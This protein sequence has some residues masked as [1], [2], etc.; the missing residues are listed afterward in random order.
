VRIDEVPITPE[1]IMKA[2]AEK[3]AGRKPRF[4]PDHFPRVNW[5]EALRVP[6]PWEGGDGNAV[7]DVHREK[8]RAPKEKVLAP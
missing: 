6:P 3:K 4:G 2:L 7:N 1:K 8:P 5:P